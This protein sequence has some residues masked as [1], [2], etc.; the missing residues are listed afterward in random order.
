MTSEIFNNAKNAKERL[1]KISPTMCMAK[2]LQVSMHLPQGLTQS[3]YHP[4]THKIPLSEL[5]VTPRA[6]HNTHEKV[7]QRKQMWNGERPSGCQ[8]CWN[9]EDAGNMS[10]RHYRSSEDW[11]G[12]DG[13]K[14]V[15][16]G[17]WDENINPRYV[18]VNFNQACNF[19]C[20]YCSPHLSTEWEKEILE[21][22]SL[23]LENNKNHNDINSLRN[24][25]LM[26]ITG[27]N[28]ENPYIQA[29]WEWWP[30]LYKDLRIFRMTG[31]EPLMDKNTFR[32]LEYVDK[33]PNQDIEISITSNM[34]PPDQK[35][36]DK[37]LTA[38]KNMEA[39]R[40]WEDPE[41]I[42]PYTNNNW[43][44]APACRYFSLYISV[45][46]VG[47]QAEYIRTGLNFDTL[48]SNTKKM[49]TETNGTSVTFINTFN[50]LSIPKLKDFLQ[51]ILDLRTEF[52]FDKQE[53]FVASP[54]DETGKKRGPFVRSPRQRIW[55][56]IPYLRDPNWMSAQNAA[57]IPELIEIL[58]NCI[59]FMEE[60]RATENYE[61]TYHGFL[62]HEIAKLKR[63]L[64][65]VMNGVDKEELKT[66]KRH[67]YKY[68]NQIDKR[69]NTNFIQTFP[70]LS[71]WWN[72]C[73]LESGK[74]NEKEQRVLTRL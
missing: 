65:W 31:G 38:I 47:E 18:E 5:K 70:E 59:S 8:Y 52:G 28:K 73:A 45:D 66:R 69:R 49:L 51:M 37:F 23:Q 9:I 39:V 55:F 15:E 58:N 24:A 13:W 41:K 71:K 6:L 34:C 4:P 54:I 56:D 57:H 22:G 67:F 26:P 64:V 21:Y 74:N 72:D 35:L 2:W 46:S 25:G 29:F 36:F 17:G 12:E 42:N 30:E 11:V 63:D 14:T 48:L 10:D 62:D 1:E 40:I 50:L 43:F 3:C 27:S 68:F 61:E 16:E 44:V 32:V 20:T 7:K 60:N 53:V 33:N 19:K